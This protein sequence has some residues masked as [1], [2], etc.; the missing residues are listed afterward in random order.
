MRILPVYCFQFDSLLAAYLPEL[1]EHMQKEGVI[2][3][4]YLVGWFQTLFVYVEALPQV[5]SSNKASS[6]ELSTIAGDCASYLGHIRIR[7]VLEGAL[8]GCPG[9]SK[10]KCPFVYSRLA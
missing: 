7:A 4:L 8:S 1:R 10:G 9:A 2:S 3:E 5:Q 6:H